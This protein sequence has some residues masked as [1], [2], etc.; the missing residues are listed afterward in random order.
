MRLPRESDFTPDRLAA[1]I[2]SLAAERLVDLV[3]KTA[4]TSR[5]RVMNLG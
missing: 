5:Q 2:S 4:A 3:E 1:E